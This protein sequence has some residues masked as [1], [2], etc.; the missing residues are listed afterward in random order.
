[1]LA[2]FTYGLFEDHDAWPDTVDYEAPNSVIFARRALVHYKRALGDD[3]QL[4]LG[5]EN[6]DAYIDVS[7]APLD[8]D[9]ETGA[10]GRNQAPDGGFNVRWTPRGI[11]DHMQFSTI[12]RGLGI[13]GLTVEDQSVFAWGINLSASLNFGQNDSAQFWFVYGDGVGG[14]GNDTSFLD[15]DAAIDV[16]G[17]LHTLQY[18]SALGAFTHHWTPRWRSTITYGYVN[19]E[20]VPGQAVTAYHQSHYGSVNVIYQIFKRLSIG[21]EGL[22]GHKEVF[23]GR[24]ATIYRIQLGV[25]FAVFD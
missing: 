21:L 13:D 4:T 20:N 5:L 19:L 1:M 6:P 24:S 12:F 14:M 16:N 10:I 23:D 22:G 3:W 7:G 15:S 17:V 11:V 8:S 9:G 25:S 18:G 2:G